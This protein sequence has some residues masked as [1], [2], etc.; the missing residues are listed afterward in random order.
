MLYY[1]LALFVLFSLILIIQDIKYLLLP[2]IYILLLSLSLITFDIFLNKSFIL[3]GIKGFVSCGLFFLF[4]YFI[5][6]KKLGFGDVKYSAVIGYFLGLPNWIF[7]VIFACL[8][9]IVFY[10][11]G[12]KKQS[13]TKETKIPFGPFLAAGSIFTSIWSMK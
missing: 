12:V 5:S 9:A 10:Y 8:S 11:I 13:W 4:I 7:A 6:S 3:S 1:R 2:D